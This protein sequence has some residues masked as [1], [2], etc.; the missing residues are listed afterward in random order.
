MN[1]NTPQPSFELPTP[2]NH[3]QETG[4]SAPEQLPGSKEA[5]ATASPQPAVVPPPNIPVPPN[6]L[7]PP[8]PAAQIAA[9]SSTPAVA[10]DSD[11][12]EKEW[13][14]KAKQIVASTRED[15]YEQNKQMSRFKADYLKK[16]YNK[17]IKLEGI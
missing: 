2:V 13:V 4:S 17:D 16:R 1:P 6:P 7:P 14:E 3:G 5:P 12:I 8:D 10:D 9:P 11:L 15:P